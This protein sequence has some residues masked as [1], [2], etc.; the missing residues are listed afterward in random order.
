MKENNFKKETSLFRKMKEKELLSGDLKLTK[1]VLNDPVNFIVKATQHI[2]A[3]DKEIE[4]DSIG[5]GC[6]IQYRDRLFLISVAHVADEKGIQACIVT[7]QPPKDGKTPLYSVGAMTFIDEFKIKNLDE[8]K[9]DKDLTKIDLEK[10]ETLD[11]T[12]VELKEP[13]DILQN[14][15]NFGEPFPIVTAGQKIIL[16]NPPMNHV[17]HADEEYAFAGRI[18]GHLKENQLVST[19]KFVPM[20]AYGGE[21]GRYYKFALPHIITDVKDYKGTSGAPIFDSQ[22][23]LVALVAHCFKGEPFIYGFKASVLKQFLDFAIDSK[24]I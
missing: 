13:I 22:G 8:L 14:E 7:G 15:I 6:I 17:P 24:T 4:P 3:V 2:V 18:R 10:I 9:K 11:I 12:F 5:S 20:L 19:E 21:E 23:N 1:G 16:D